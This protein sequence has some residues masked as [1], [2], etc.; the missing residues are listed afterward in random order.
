M[1]LFSM[2]SRSLFVL[3]FELRFMFDG[4]ATSL[5]SILIIHTMS[6]LSN[7]ILGIYDL[8]FHTLPSQL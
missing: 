8:L 4:F 6:S 7:I 3:G 5:A 1:L 2:C